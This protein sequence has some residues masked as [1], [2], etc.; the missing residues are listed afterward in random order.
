MPRF[1]PCTHVHIHSV[2]CVSVLVLLVY[3][4]TRSVVCNPRNAYAETIDDSLK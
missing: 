4:R 3:I 2:A 1:S